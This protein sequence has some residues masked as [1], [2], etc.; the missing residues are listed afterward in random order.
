M[1]K[2]LIFQLI[3]LASALINAQVPESFTYQSLV[4]DGSG[5]VLAD[6]AVSFLFA[7]VAGDPGGSAVYSEKHNLT[8]NAYGL[9]SLSIGNGI[10]K[11]GSFTAIDWS[12]GSYFLNVKIDA[13][14]SGTYIDMGT[15]QLLS[16]PYALFAKTSGSAGETDPLFSVSL[17]SAI[18]QNDTTRWGEKILQ[19]LSAVLSTGNMASGTGIISL[20]PTSINTAGASPAEKAILDISSSSMG[21]LIPRMN[22]T[23]INNITDPEPGL[24]LMD[25]TGGSFNLMVFNGVEWTRMIYSIVP[26]YG[27]VLWNELGSEQEIAEGLIGP[28]GE[29]VGSS[30]AFEPAHSGNGY[31]RKATGSN[32][33]KFPGSVLQNL[34]K[35]GTVELWINPKVPNPVAYSYGVFP[36]FGNTFGSNSH[37]YIAWGDITSGTGIYGGVNFDGTGHYTPSE[38]SQFVAVPG[39]PFH[40]AVCWDIDGI[41][42][43][44]NT[45]RVFRNGEVVGTS[46][47]LWDSENTTVN[48]DGFTLG[49]GPDGDGYDKYIVDDLRVWN[50][51]RTS[52]GTTKSTTVVEGDLEVGGVIRGDI[53]V[54]KVHV[55]QITGLLGQ[56]FTM[57][58]PD[59][60]NNTATLEIPSIL[61]FNDKILVISGPGTETERISTPTFWNPTRQMQYYIE[62][63][64]LTMEYPFVFEVSDAAD[65]T[66]LKTWFDNP[67]AP[68]ANAALIIRNSDGTETCRWTFS[69]YI[70]DGYEAGNDGRTRFTIKHNRLPD[71]I[72]GCEFTGEF[73][74]RHLYEHGVDTRVDFDG[75]ST[76]DRF[77]PKVEWDT[78]NRTVTLTF[79]YQEGYRIYDWVK[80]TIAGTEPNRVMSVIYTTDGSTEIYRN[81]FFEIVPIRYDHFYG[82]GQDIKLKA[83]LVI[84]YGFWEQG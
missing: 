9:V 64:G 14:M 81:N 84:A 65:V 29:I 72:N 50:H 69:N 70:P 82:F 83:R 26:D 42:G 38:A 39:V 21:V 2:A 60:L 78:L 67:S 47:A 61:T 58:F 25:T 59:V 73:G 20:G 54:D 33:V 66:A 75:V 53:E 48:Y 18:T 5:M 45:I 40:I 19:S 37:V 52:F 12:S 1:K 6:Q 16:V 36:L 28:G 68:E 49:M 34:K 17:A 63:T 74:D 31:V 27:L 41:E 32:Y 77:A 43:S 30:Y 7:I 15:T 80:R 46:D 71:N 55:S 11:T 8:T 35:R 44:T 13:S 10:E 51:A 4:R 79:E 24:I 22:T 56:G 62:D 57:M 3:V 76:G 23:Q